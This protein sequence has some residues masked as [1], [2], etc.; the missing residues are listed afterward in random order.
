MKQ[1]Y[2]NGEKFIDTVEASADPD[3]VVTCSDYKDIDGVEI[4]KGSVVTVGRSEKGLVSYKNG[5]FVLV[6]NPFRKTYAPDIILSN[7]K[8]K[9]FRIRVIGHLFEHPRFFN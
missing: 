1:K 5:T 9:R 4:W 3:R 2:W 6:K 7:T 8:I